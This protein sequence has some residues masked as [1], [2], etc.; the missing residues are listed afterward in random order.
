M[1]NYNGGVQ[2][3]TES[4]LSIFLS[5]Q[6]MHLPTTTPTLQQYKYLYKRGSMSF[7]LKL[8]LVVS[9]H[10]S[11][12]LSKGKITMVEICSKLDADPFCCQPLNGDLISRFWEITISLFH[13]VIIKFLDH[14]LDSRGKMRGRCLFSLKWAP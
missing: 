12:C 1:S 10:H 9:N 6:H 7:P 4:R 8:K 11:K 14:T 2:A 13:L 5:L 3:T